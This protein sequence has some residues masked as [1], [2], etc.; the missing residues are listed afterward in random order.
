MTR[1]K[2]RN[3]QKR[4]RARK[5]RMGEIDQNFQAVRSVHEICPDQTIVTL[6][7]PVI[8]NIYTASAVTS[9]KRWQPNAAYDVDPTLGST[10]TPGFTEWSAFYTY[11]RVRK[12]RVEVEC[13]NMDPLSMGVF[14]CH[15]N[16]DPGT[17]GANYYSYASQAFGT[18][19]MLSPKGGLDR[20]T[21]VQ[22]VPVAQLVGAVDVSTDDSLRA[23]VTTVPADL[24]F[25]GIG[26]RTT[27]GGNLTVGV[28]VI[29]YI[30]MEVQF[31][32]RKNTLT[33]LLGPLIKDAEEQRV[34]QKMISHSQNAT[35][36]PNSANEQCPHG[37]DRVDVLPPSIV[38]TCGAGKKCASGW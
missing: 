17:G 26:I 24:V 32:G 7:Y 18:Q 31:Y 6:R 3:Q 20:V 36:R 11:Y 27:T 10:S 38:H 9:A 30:D 37:L 33:T 4:A 1:G 23:S 19:K 13:V 35:G 34:L 15:L 12:Y 28:D 22:T 29:G 8:V 14:F 16:T 21:Y 5:P 25:F 2:N